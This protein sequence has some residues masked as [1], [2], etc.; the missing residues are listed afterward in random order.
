MPDPLLGPDGR[1]AHYRVERQPDGAPRRLGAGSMG[2]TY[3]AWDEKLRVPVAL[4]VITPAHAADPRAHAL[5]VREARAAARVRHPNVAGVLF[6]SDEP[7]RF[8]YAM[9][10][11]AG[12][13]LDRWLRARGPLPPLLA[14]DLAAQVARGLGAIHAQRIVHRDLK[15]PNVI[16]A[17]ASGTDAGPERWEAKIIDFGLARAFQ[18]GELGEASA[19]LTTGFRGTA[20]Y[21]S[22]EQ[23]E[24]WADL[25]GRS[26]LYSLGCILWEM[27]AG[28]PPFRGRSQRA[29][30]NLHTT[31]APP[32]AVL[33]AAPPAVL[34]IL[35]R[36]L[37]KDRNERFP[38]AT[39]LVAAL[40]GARNDLLA[41]F[42]GALPLAV[43]VGGAGGRP[44]SSLAHGSTRPSSARSSRTTPGT[45]AVREPPPSRG[46]RVRLAAAVAL[47]AT[48]VAGAALLWPRPPAAATATAPERSVAVLPF[49][50]ASDEPD[51]KFFADGV[52]DDVLTSLGKVSGLRV[53]GRTSVMAYRGA[54]VAS[55]REIG[56]A[57]GVG[58]LV[59]G[60]VRRAAGRVLVSVRLLDAR[61]ERQVWAERYDRTLADVLTL[62]GELA[63][64]IAGALRSSLSPAERAAVATRPTAN[65]DA[66]VLWL[67]ARELEFAADPSR[68]RWQEAERCYAQAVALD[69]AFALAHAGL[70]SVRSRIGHWYEPTAQRR[71]QA[72]EAAETALRLQPSLGEARKS[73]AL[74]RYWGDRDFAAAA[75][76]FVAAGEVL[77][78]DPDVPFNLAAIRRRQ[79]RWDESTAGF[80]RALGLDPRSALILSELPVNFYATRRWAE[81]A[82]AYERALAVSPASLDLRVE[83]ARADF[84]RAGDLAPLRAVL[85]TP[86]ARPDDSTLARWWLHTRE[87][88]WAAAE[89][90]LAETA[91][92]TLEDPFGTPP[93]KILLQ[94]WIHRWRGDEEPAR[95][96]F[97]AALPAYEAA[98]QAAPRDAARRAGLGL[99][100]ALLGRADEA[101]R[102]GKLA[103]ELSPEPADALDGPK[104][105]ARH[106]LILAQLGDADAAVPLL[107]RLLTIPN[108]AYLSVQ[109]LRLSPEWDPLRGDPAFQ[110][111]A[112]GPE[113]RTEFR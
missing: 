106:A 57:L 86:A 87:R 100:L 103:T 53:V 41:T 9:E 74:C 21:A 19:A 31:E 27:L 28:A 112:A 50:N 96:C 33:A 40:D 88:D 24:E 10:F 92:E 8:F 59:E 97:A 42:S 58:Y 14:L 67:R 54:P 35:L 110:R 90:A 43:A 108:T 70:S 79:G 6:L 68:S 49:E 32:V 91:R 73:L 13:P 15:P 16:V 65:L 44:P 105:A 62:Q 1:L 102:E 48:L 25:D 4:K 94:G 75:R 72:R 7:G 45:A 69:P 71:A 78:N 111:L 17:P 18:A 84:H 85:S 83:R 101:R 95:A 80:E 5:F 47:L 20:L 61:D 99:V 107:A 30:L 81:A 37:A 26:D 98:A 38:D 89:R 29:I 23:C 66:Y 109:D 63:Q 76:E 39:A 77:P 22:P 60:R 52:Q 113:P 34:D 104:I 3:A 2:V 46:R 51:A 11:V 93:P 56:R 55:V 36:L 12:E 82:R 64:E